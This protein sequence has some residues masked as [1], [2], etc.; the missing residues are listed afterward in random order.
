M[1]ER[2]VK[3]SQF[4]GDK[5]AAAAFSLLNSED[6]ADVNTALPWAGPPATPADIEARNKLIRE[7]AGAPGAYTTEPAKEYV[8][9]AGGIK[10]SRKNLL[11]ALSNQYGKKPSLLNDPQ[12]PTLTPEAEESTKIQPD[13]AMLNDLSQMYGKKSSTLTKAPMVQRQQPE[14]V[15]AFASPEEHRQAVAAVPEA[16]QPFHEEHIKRMESTVTDPHTGM[17]IRYP[18]PSGGFSIG[19]GHKLSAD[20]LNLGVVKIGGKRVPI[21]HGLTE[22]QARSLLSEDTASKTAGAKQVMAEHGIHWES[23]PNQVQTVAAD[24][25]YQ[26]GPNGLRRFQPFLDAVKNKDWETAQRHVDR[27]YRDPHTGA[28]VLD[29]R[30]SNAAKALLNQLPRRKHR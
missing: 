11:N 1:A 3:P 21:R 2:V 15:P 14:T 4:G 5:Q 18:D 13:P 7:K 28:M 20:E 12:Q 10:N 22:E 23:L 19:Y 24:L 6:R 26:V 30:R 8:S 29:E 9:G 27:Y 25:A 17:L 16:A